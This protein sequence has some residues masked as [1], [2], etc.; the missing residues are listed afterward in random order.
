MTTAPTG[1]AMRSLRWDRTSWSRSLPAVLGVALAGI[2]AASV[3]A[4]R[5]W[6]APPTK[7]FPL[8]GGNYWH[9]RYSALDKINTSN[10]KKLGGAWMIRLEEGRPGGQLEGTPVVVDGVMYVTTGTRNA[11][12]IDA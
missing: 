9:Q 6:I 2:V 12:A 4:S 11:L 10:V 5:D 7:D 1:G 3:A 8:S